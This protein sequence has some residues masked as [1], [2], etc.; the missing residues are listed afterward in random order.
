MSSLPESLGV[1]TEAH[2]FESDQDGERALADLD[3]I[4]IV[5]LLSYRRKFVDRCHRI[6]ASK[7]CSHEK[8]A[9]QECR[10]GSN[11]GRV[12]TNTR[13]QGTSTVGA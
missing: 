8:A 3:M 5:E 10:R 11:A 7:L 9:T 12:A 6:P 1:V 2:S 4:R 13:A